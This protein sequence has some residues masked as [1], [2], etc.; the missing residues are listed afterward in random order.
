MIKHHP[1]SDLL[2]AFVRGDLPAS[3]SAAIAIHVD[4][5]PKCQAE[6]SALT[7]ENA[8]LSFEEA[9]LHKFQVDSEQ[10]ESD[11]DISEMASEIGFEQMIA[12]ITQD[13]SL[14]Q[15]VIRRDKSITVKGQ[16]YLLPRAIENM[17][18][19]KFSSIGKLARARLNLG[20]GDIHTSLLQIEAGGEIPE[21]THNGYEITLLL[22]GNFQDQMGRYEAGDFIMLDGNHQH[23]PMTKKGCLCLTVVSDSL[24]FTKGINKLLNPI[25]QFIY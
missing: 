25:G 23:S 19:G 3:V 15:P 1:K 22:D 12:S 2:Q 7:K 6:I 10:G 14:A 8:E 18:V 16:E 24:H 13:E 5:C 17:E 11:I 9:F 4:M 21:H 20:E